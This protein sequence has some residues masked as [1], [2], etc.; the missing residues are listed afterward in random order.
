MPNIH[1]TISF[2]LVSIPVIM[3]PVIRNND[4]SF[5]Q[6]HKDCMHRVSYVKYCDKCKKT[7]KLVVNYLTS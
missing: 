2:G 4:T 6:L 3:N 7:L 5:N 1:S